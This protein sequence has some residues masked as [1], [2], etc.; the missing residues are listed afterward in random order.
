MRKREWNTKIARNSN[1]RK[2]VQQQQ[3]RFRANIRKLKTWNKAVKKISKVFK[4]GKKNQIF[5]LIK[6]V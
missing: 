3:S 1:V 6:Y 5:N 4:K 2:R